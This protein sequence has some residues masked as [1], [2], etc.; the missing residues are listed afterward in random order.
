M[1]FAAILDRLD[2]IVALS[3]DR[4]SREVDWQGHR[5]R[6]GPGPHLMPSRYALPAAA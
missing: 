6:L 1:F 4:S 5:A 2:G 3:L